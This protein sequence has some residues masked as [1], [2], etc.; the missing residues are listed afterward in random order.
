MGSCVDSMQKKKVKSECRYEKNYEVLGVWK[1]GS[2]ACDILNGES[3]EEV[4][5]F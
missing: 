4:D 5:C 3:L 1:W 2:N